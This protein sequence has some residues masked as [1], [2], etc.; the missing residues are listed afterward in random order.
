MKEVFIICNHHGQFL[1]KQGQWVDESEPVLVY[2]TP[3]RDIALNHLIEVNARD[4][5][6]RLSLMQCPL[7]EKDIP[8]LGDAMPAKK[9]VPVTFDDEPAITAVE[10]T[11][12]DAADTEHDD[13]SL[14][15]NDDAG[16]AD[17]GYPA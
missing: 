11:D 16:V 8:L 5:E 7:N 14:A 17:I 1:G 15:V 13:A 6:Q 4:I 10:E 9:S 12:S 3:H 2:R